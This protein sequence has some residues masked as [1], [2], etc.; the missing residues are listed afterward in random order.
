[1]FV[2]PLIVEMNT[3]RHQEEVNADFDKYLKECFE[4]HMRDLFPKIT[5]EQII[6]VAEIDKTM[7]RMGMHGF[8]NAVMMLASSTKDIKDI[9]TSLL[10]LEKQAIKS[11]EKRLREKLLRDRPPIT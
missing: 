9:K 10:T 1:M 2:N 8:T 6:K 11:E 5:D 4:R 7:A 3:K